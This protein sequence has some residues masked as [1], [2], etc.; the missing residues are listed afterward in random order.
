MDLSPVYELQERLHTA[1]I[2]GA[3][4]LNE[5]FRLRRAA[6]AIKPLA[7]ASPVFAKLCQQTDL[8]LSPGCSAP[9]SV[10]LDTISLA[11]AI[12]CTLGTVET[13]QETTDVE[14]ALNPQTEEY[15]TDNPYIFNVPYSQV[16]TLI[17]AL[18]TTGGGN[19]SIVN[20]LLHTFPDIFK[21]YRIRHALVRALGAQYYELVNLVRNYLSQCGTE[22]IPL[23]KKDF[24]PK[25]KKEMVH[26][27]NIITGI[28]GASENDFYIEML[29]TATGDVRTALIN[30]LCNEP[31]NSGRLLSM[32]KTERG[33][34]KQCVLNILGKMESVSESGELYNLFKQTIKKSPSSAL[35]AL[36]PSTTIC[37]SRIIAEECMEQLPKII[38]AIE[39]NNAAA[40]EKKLTPFCRLIE[41]LPGKH[42]DEACLC[43]RQ[44]LSKSK[45]LDQCSYK[46]AL[47][48][49]DYIPGNYPMV[50]SRDT[51]FQ[52]FSR[53]NFPPRTARKLTWELI[54]GSHIAQSLVIFPGSQSRKMAMKLFENSGNSINF[55]TAAAFVQILENNNCTRWFDVQIKQDASAITEIQRALSYIKWDVRLNSYVTNM[56]FSDM[57]WED[58][59]KFIL[60]KIEIPDA[61]RIQDW[62][63]EQAS[64]PQDSSLLLTKAGVKKSGKKYN[65][66]YIDEILNRWINTTDQKQCEKAGS[67][68]YNRALSVQDNTDYL[69]YMLNCKWT[70]CKGLAARFARN[71][72][73]IQMWE[74][75]DYLYHLPGNAGT[76]HKIQKE[77]D[78]VIEIIKSGSLVVSNL[79]IDTERAQNWFDSLRDPANY[80]CSGMED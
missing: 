61:S 16:K 9:A 65:L 54:I 8:L 11:D 30:A 69:N 27:V 39:K 24:D 51:D 67:Y 48:V 43:Y 38:E 28:A 60:N 18:T 46:P 4:L 44:L 41:A 45:I 80:I 79:N 13:K 3:N 15:R 52:L 36:M 21:D 10:L 37:A 75:T 26:R 40:I 17:N 77:I 22:I 59:R 19:Y 63:M 73:K 6:K 57:E 50:H 5:D 56:L 25:G 20:D 14:L 64:Q 76:I 66:Q 31:A 2:A 47:E 74:L 58:S 71:K 53:Q 42:G 70:E 1:I 34:N 35:I 72:K 29:E 62:M 7:S 68:F 32:A 23:L 12:I 33:R 55:L 49:L 78:A